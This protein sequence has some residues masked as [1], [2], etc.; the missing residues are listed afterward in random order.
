M[1]YKNKLES[2]SIYSYNKIGESLLLSRAALL[3][4]FDK[5]LKNKELKW[6]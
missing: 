2:I 3:C 5:L 1:I 6:H 4:Y